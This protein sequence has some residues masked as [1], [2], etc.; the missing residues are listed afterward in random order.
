MFA[1]VRE[2]SKKT[3]CPQHVS[4]GSKVKL[5][6]TEIINPQTIT[7]TMH[8][9]LLWSDLAIVVVIHLVIVMYIVVGLIKLTSVN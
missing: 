8:L 2:L 9:W 1:E 4:N 6:N 5:R 3:S 7:T